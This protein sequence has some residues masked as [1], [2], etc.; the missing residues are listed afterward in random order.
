LVSRGYD[1]IRL[2]FKIGFLGGAVA[3]GLSIAQLAL[4]I[5]TPFWWSNS[6][7]ISGE[8]LLVSAAIGFIAGIF[9]LYG[10]TVGKK[11]GGGIMIV[12]G[13]LISIA[14]SI[15]VMFFGPVL[16]LGGL[17]ALIEKSCKNNI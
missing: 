3:T 13:I 7:Y 12:T 1:G 10:A 17:I 9:G 4:R 15:S 8:A 5:R 2:S 14:T 16:F 6:T 11:L